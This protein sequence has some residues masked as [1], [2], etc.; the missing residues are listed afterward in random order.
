MPSSTAA[1]LGVP[2][3]DDGVAFPLGAALRS[4]SYVQRLQHVC[5]FCLS[6]VGERPGRQ[7][8]LSGECLHDASWH[9]HSSFSNGAGLRVVP[10]ATTSARRREQKLFSPP[11]WQTSPCPGRNL[12]GRAYLLRDGTRTVPTWSL[13]RSGEPRR[14]MPQGQ[15]ARYSHGTETGTRLSVPP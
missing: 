6:R 5:S 8:R 12:P 11:P 1:R 10:D 13:R 9:K 3:P 14:H 7:R 15:A 4:A 2:L